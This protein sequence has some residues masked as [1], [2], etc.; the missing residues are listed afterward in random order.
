MEKYLLFQMILIK[1]KEL[2]LSVLRLFIIFPLLISISSCDVDDMDEKETDNS[3]CDLLSFSLMVANNPELVTDIIFNRDEKSETFRAYCLNWTE[4]LKPHAE[5]IPT[6]TIDGVSLLLDGKELISGKSKIDL[7][8]DVTLVVKSKNK[9]KQFVVSFICPQINNEIPVIRLFAS[10]DTITRD[11][12]ITA[13]AVVYDTNTGIY[14]WDE[15]AGDV[16][17]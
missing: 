13:K 12:Y 1:R 2:L 14:E 5:F 10:P 7:A 11:D 6:F 8:S 9:Q 4:E 17:I 3:S 16:K 15:N